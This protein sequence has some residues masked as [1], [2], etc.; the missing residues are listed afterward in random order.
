M[1]AKEPDTDDAP[2]NATADLA[3]FLG[4]LYRMDNG[5]PVTSLKYGEDTYTWNGESTRKGSNWEKD[6]A[7]LVS[8]LVQQI[9]KEMRID[10][11]SEP[12]TDAQSSFEITIGEVV[13]TFNITVEAQA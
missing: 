7:T 3:R 6:G 13:V 1:K 4:A 12:E 8:A 5:T 9:S 2:T 10:G 11:S